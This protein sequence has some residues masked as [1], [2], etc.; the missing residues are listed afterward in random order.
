MADR[1]LP[2]EQRGSRRDTVRWGGGLSSSTIKIDRSRGADDGFVAC[3]GM[4]GPGVSIGFSSREVV[5]GFACRRVLGA[6][7]SVGFSCERESDNGAG[8]VGSS[9][10]A[11]QS[12]WVDRAPQE[13]QYWC[14]AT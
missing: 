5:D 9:E 12:H 1:F 4:V 2:S 14:A 10:D 3:K 7:G 11:A 6:G 13:F 8:V